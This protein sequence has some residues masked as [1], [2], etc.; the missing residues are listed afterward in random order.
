MNN[1]TKQVLSLS[2][3]ILSDRRLV[4]KNLGRVARRYFRK[5][6]TFTEVDALL[7]RKTIQVLKAATL[8]VR[9][10]NCERTCIAFLYIV[11]SHRKSQ[12]TTNILLA[13]ALRDTN[14]APA[15]EYYN[16]LRVYSAYFASK[17]SIFF[18]H[19]HLQFRSCIIVT[20][21]DSVTDASE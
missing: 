16:T 12:Q 3:D 13:N 21:S 1:E 14:P 4:R 5:L 17:S 10:R 19:F 6:P 11:D 18:I 9:T 15:K 20:F 2:L 8:F 7:L